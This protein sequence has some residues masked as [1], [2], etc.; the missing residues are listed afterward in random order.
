[1]SSDFRRRWGLPEEDFNKGLQKSIYRILAITGDIVDT[2]ES[3][4]KLFAFV[5]GV[6]KEA[7]RTTMGNFNMKK[8][9]LGVT[10]P[11]ILAEKIEILFGTHVLTDSQKETVMVVINGDNIGVRVVKDG[12]GSYLTYPQGEPMLDEKVVDCALLALGDSKSAA[13][14]YT[15][16]LKAYASGK[17]NDASNNT[18]R[19]LEEYLRQYLDNQ[20]GLSTNIKRLGAL[21]KGGVTAD[22][23]RN[24]IINQITTLDKHYNEGSK[25]G[26]I[27]QGAVEA[28]YLIYSVGIII[29]TLAQIKTLETA[30]SD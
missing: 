3:D 22:H 26:S 20:A 21:L 9:I 29:N 14:E 11:H 4:L 24:S 23:F 8:Y 27:T 13:S 2:Y 16:A 28:E 19:A 6:P 18:R 5:A 15:K 10:E 17:W 12:E 30:P 25:H 1:M 7:Y